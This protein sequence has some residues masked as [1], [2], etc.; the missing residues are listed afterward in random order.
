MAD[1][2]V[3][4]FLSSLTRGT[5]CLITHRNADLDAVASALTLREIISK[6]MYVDDV[7]VIFPD[8]MDSLSKFFLNS[9]DVLNSHYTYVDSDFHKCCD[10]YVVV[11]AASNEQLGRFSDLETYS[12]V[13]HHEVN[14]LIDKAEIKLYDPKRKSTSEI[15]A[16]LAL[17]SGV[18]LSDRYYTLLI[19]GILY[20]SRS[21]YL[22]DEVTFSILSE[23]IRL[24]GNYVR[25]RN[26]LTRRT[27]LDYSER[28]ARLKGMSRLGIYKAGKYLIVIT[29]IGAYEG[30]TLRSLLDNGADVAVALAHRD[31]GFRVTI[32][33]SEEVVDELG[34]PLAG[35]LATYLA[36]KLGG[37]GGGHSSASGSIIKCGKA[38]EVLRALESYF[39]SLMGN[40]KIV[41]EGRWLEE[42]SQHG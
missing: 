14:T 36:N 10:F 26:L 21:L 32:R 41:D 9:L 19:G 5:H 12:L 15:V 1:L 17:K 40:F 35:L 37:S 31:G 7:Y 28:I 22:A 38:E 2:N 29:C 18:E 11:D 6:K 33:V 20:D 30:N 27:S 24:G 25:A 13:D 8:G 16:Y 23:L 42:C 34:R 39:R 4:K 3:D